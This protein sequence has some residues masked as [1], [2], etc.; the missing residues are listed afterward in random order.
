M[1]AGPEP[2]TGSGAGTIRLGDVEATPVVE[3]HGPIRTLGEI[4][5]QA[6]RELRERH[7]DSLSPEHWAPDTD[8][9]HAAV[10]TWVLRSGGL[11]VLVDTGVGND[12]ERPHAPAFH[13][14]RTDFL[15]R[16]ARAGVR[17]QDVDVVV[18]THVHSDHVGWNTRWDGEAWV[19]TFPNARYLIPAADHRYFDPGNLHRRPA[20]RSE[21]DRARMRG[22][23]L[24]HD[25]SIAPVV[26]AGRAELWEGTHRIDGALTL[27]PAPGH[28]PGSSVVRLES[29]GHRAVFVGDVVHS[30]VQLL[31]PDC[32]SCFCEDLALARITRRAVLARAADTGALVLPAHFAGSGQVRVRRDGSAF[33]FEDQPRR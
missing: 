33:A 11:T 22:D 10:R 17:P 24:V 20:P 14:W 3:W 4:V 29:G 30:P 2:G 18:N 25:D 23:A 1:T 31:E 6:S 26:A 19:P 5:P 15:D 21:A 9:W 32:N 16:L 8:A 28:T 13:R 27:E 12:K 7:R